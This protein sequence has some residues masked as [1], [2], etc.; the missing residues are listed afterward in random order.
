MMYIQVIAGF[1]FLQIKIVVTESVVVHV[2]V[3]YSVN[4]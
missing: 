4:K 1:A 3:V 2:Y